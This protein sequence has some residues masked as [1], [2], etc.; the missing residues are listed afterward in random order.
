MAMNETYAQ[1][2]RFDGKELHGA[3]VISP[4]LSRILPEKV[5]FPL[6][7]SGYKKFEPTVTQNPMTIRRFIIVNY[8][9]C[10][11]FRKESNSKRCVPIFHSCQLK[12]KVT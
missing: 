9:D 7:P 11:I 6:P 8:S 3:R 10:E 4:K 5:L 1:R 2:Q 12:D